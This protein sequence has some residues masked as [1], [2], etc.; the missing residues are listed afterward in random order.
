MSKV[1]DIKRLKN[2]YLHRIG[3][4]FDN[5][6]FVAENEFLIDAYTKDEVIA[7]LDDIQ[8][9]IAKLPVHAV[10]NKG[11]IIHM[12]IAPSAEDV[13]ELIQEKIN[14]LRGYTNEEDENKNSSII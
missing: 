10:S 9:E 5:A 11:L 3:A 12:E 13:Y 4:Q 1:V 7:M 2:R 6:I 8:S 14:A